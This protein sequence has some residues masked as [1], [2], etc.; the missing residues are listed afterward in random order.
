LKP[1]LTWLLKAYQLHYMK[2][3]FSWKRKILGLHGFA[4]PVKK[5]LDNVLKSGLAV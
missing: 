3:R 5:P 1:N 4:E 2:S